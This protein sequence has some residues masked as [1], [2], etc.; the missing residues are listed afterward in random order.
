MLPVVAPLTPVLNELE[1]DEGAA[2]TLHA[3]DLVHEGKALS[4]LRWRG[5]MEG[6]EGS[7]DD[8]AF[9]LRPIGGAATNYGFRKDYGA[10]LRVP[11][12]RWLCAHNGTVSAD[13]D[14][15]TRSLARARSPRGAIVAWQAH[16]PTPTSVSVVRG[17]VVRTIPVGVISEARLVEVA[18]QTLL[19][20]TIR[21]AS[22][23]GDQSGGELLPVRVDGGAVAKFPPLAL[24]QIDARDSV[25]VTTRIVT[26]ELRN[27]VVR[28]RGTRRVVARADGHELESTPIDESHRLADLVVGL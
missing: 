4:P 19:I 18:G 24:D 28:I 9:E 10:P 27:G 14:T 17:G 15:C 21:T 6:G 20:L 8:A 7:R 22:P 26:H 1:D 5:L 12:A 16:S 11:T 23:T 25:R 2:M 13:R 3:G